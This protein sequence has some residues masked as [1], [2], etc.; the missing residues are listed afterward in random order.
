MFGMYHLQFH[1]K[2]IKTFQGFIKVVI[3]ILEITSPVYC[4]TNYVMNPTVYRKRVIKILRDICVQQPSFPK[5]TE[6]C[7]KLIRRINDEDGQLYF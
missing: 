2:I 7:I 3:K 5:L 6:I 4:I 1:D